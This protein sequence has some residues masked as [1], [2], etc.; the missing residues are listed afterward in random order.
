MKLL[1]CIKQV[2][3]SGSEIII[4]DSRHG[5]TYS[6]VTRFEIN[7]YDEY[8]I[9]EAILI[10]EKFGNVHI[11][12]ITVGPSRSGD[13]L[14][15]ALGIGADEAIHI[16]DE[17]KG[18]RPPITT[19]SWIAEV[20][21]DR[22]YDLILTGIMSDDE[23]N[24]QTGPM[25][26]QILN[27]PCAGTIIKEEISSD[28]KTIT[29]EREIEGGAKDVFQ[30]DLPCVLAVQ[31]GINSP[32]Y[33][34]LSKVMRAKKKTFDLILAESLK[35][36]GQQPKLHALGFPQKMSHGIVLEGSPQEKA[37]QLLDILVSKSLA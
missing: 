23:M 3:E 1:V 15:R 24:G 2:M 17:T 37:V 12:A 28:G 29:I 21:K 20:A 18:Y 6:N 11:D 22:N 32:R 5:L 8:A 9:E 25:I 27:R 30:I 31:T 7:K 4:D 35:K 33:P 10:K 36:P 19:A 16:L 26:A 13:A 34:S 14:R